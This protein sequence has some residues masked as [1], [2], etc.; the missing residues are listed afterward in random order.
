[1]TQANGPTVL[2]VDDEP[3]IRGLLQDL[4]AEEGYHV[5]AAA[6]GAAA[7]VAVQS[8]TPDLVVADL[9]MPGMDGR[10]LA[11]KLHA[12]DRTAHIPVVLMSAAYLPQSTDAFAA[13]IQ[14]PFDL[15]E[16]LETIR[17]YLP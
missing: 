4:L 1:M 3:A 15:D 8:Q 12:D 7:L 2:V 9:M 10:T 11:A 5:L 13:V 14:K 16:I 6:E 17:P